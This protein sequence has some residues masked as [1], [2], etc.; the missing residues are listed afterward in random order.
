MSE[1]I[2]TALK[3]FKPSS[4]NINFITMVLEP[5]GVL[6]QT[7]E[8]EQVRT[9]KVADKTGSI[10]LCIFG[11]MG[12]Y[13]KPGDIIRVR[14]YASLFKGSLTA[15]VG[16]TGEIRRVGEFCLPISEVPNMS[17]MN[18]FPPLPV[19]VQGQGPERAAPPNGGN[20]HQQHS[21]NL[22]LAA[23]VE[24]RVA[25]FPQPDQGGLPSQINKF[26]TR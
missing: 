5:I 4:K 14:G 9:F 26:G 2:L 24:P 12:G 21:A 15:Y 25:H 11:E 17:E 13:L 1:I 20:F 6:H 22:M 10:N 3:D 16:K 23:A 19:H 7:R 18:L 8:G